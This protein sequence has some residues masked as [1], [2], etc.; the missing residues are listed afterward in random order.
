MRDF[1][2]AKAMAQSLRKALSGASHA[3]T[4]SESLEL[5]A[6][7]FGLADWNV[8]A[9]KIEAATAPALS[10]AEAG[11]KALHCSFCDKS[12]YVVAQL[13]AGPNVFICS[14]CVGLCDSIVTDTEVAKLI[15]QYRTHRAEGDPVDAASEYLRGYAENQLTAYQASNRQWLANL[16]E[17][18][19]KTE[20]AME[21]LGTSPESRLEPAAPGGRKPDPLA[22]KTR[23]E[24]IAHRAYVV[25][26][27][28]QVRE[29]LRVTEQVLGE[30][31]G[32]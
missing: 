1:R 31:E 15:E 30:R 28:D 4:H 5:V 24:L 17:S 19:E 27:R 22:G 8:L 9:A 12:Q 20:A 29:R 3:V 6:K 14:E 18:I 10:A 23:D 11:P 21:R 25:R 2:D 26:Q 16:E 32:A 13:I 7:A